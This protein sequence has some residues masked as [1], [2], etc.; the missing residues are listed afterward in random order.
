[1]R[2]A[3]AS[4]I[5]VGPTQ[6]PSAIVALLGAFGGPIATHHLTLAGATAAITVGGATVIAL[7][8]ARC[9][10]LRDA[11]AAGLRAT[12]RGATVAGHVVS[13]HGIAL[14]G[15]FEHTVAAHILRE[16]GLAAAV[17]TRRVAVVALLTATDLQY[18]VTAHFRLAHG[19]ATIAIGGV[20]V[21]AL[22]SAL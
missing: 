10:A 17:T 19:R 13:R 11:I 6:T 5:D 2:I 8:E 21:I 15:A 20:S 9:S 12:R 22:F 16:A 18:A 7:L 14:L 3:G 1:L 4:Q